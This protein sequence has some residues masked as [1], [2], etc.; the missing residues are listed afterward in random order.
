LRLVNICKIYN[1]GGIAL[2]ILHDINFSVGQGEF[3]TIMGASGSGKTTLLNIIA[4][5]D[6]PSSGS[7]FFN[8]DQV[9]SLEDHQLSHVR[10]RW[11]GFVFQSFNL[12]PRLPAWRNVELPLIYQEVPPAKRKDI[13][14]QMLT[15]VGLGQKTHR[16]PGELSGG[17]QQRVAI[18]R[19]LATQ[20][21]LLLA[22]EPTGNLDSKTGNEIIGILQDLHLKGL[23]IVMVTHS[24][25]MTIYSDRTIVI[26]DGRIVE[27]AG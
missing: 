27:G 8:G 16:L 2:E 22:D 5:L 3:V 10:N 25:E 7:Y 21:T 6:R 26:R 11:I 19:A 15:S 14:A 13:A 24:P 20:P 4:C 9:E 1:T 23:T 12:L 18:A 17:E